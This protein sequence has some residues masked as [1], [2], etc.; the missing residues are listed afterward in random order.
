MNRKIYLEDIPLEDA[1]AAFSDSLAAA[2]LWE[3]LPPEV[4]NVAQA[5]GRVT[6]IPTWAKISAPHYHASAMDG[7]ALRSSDSIKATET[8]PIQ[9]T[10][11]EIDQEGHEIQYPA[12]AVNTGQPIPL[13]ADCVV[14]VE[15]AQ[16]IQDSFPSSPRRR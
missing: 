14:M 16:P 7:F 3:P 6:A 11:I 15:H 1:R 8:N 4:V 9:F 10:I 12:L 13:W 2:G 5:R